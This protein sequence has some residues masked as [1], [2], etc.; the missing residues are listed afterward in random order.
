MV[1][2]GHLKEWRKQGRGGGG[3]QGR[4]PGEQEKRRVYQRSRE[5]ASLS[6]WKSPPREAGSATGSWGEGS[7]CSKSECR[8]G[9]TTHQRGAAPS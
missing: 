8:K 4:G 3:G 5:G 2:K 9:S 7:G 6:I 1:E